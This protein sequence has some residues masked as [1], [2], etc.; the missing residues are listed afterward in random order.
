MFGLLA[1]SLLCL[2]PGIASSFPDDAPKIE[3]ALYYE[4]LCPDCQL[5]IRQQLYPTYLKVSDIINL[6][7]VPYG[8]AEER[9]IGDKWVFQCQHGPKECEGNLIETCAI[10]LLKDISASLPFVYCFEKNIEGSEE[11]TTVAQ[12]C[13]KSL[14]IDYDSIE[15]CVSGPLGNEL[16][17]KM[18]AMTDALEP[19]HQYVPWVTVNGKH[20]EK[21][22]NMAQRNLLK[23]VC[24]YY[25]GPK[26]KDCEKQEFGRCYKKVFPLIELKKALRVAAPVSELH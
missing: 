3:L 10:S 16:E 18:A 12:S 2:M 13:A 9:K 15:A 4:S 17:H 26:P 25:T 7:L 19:Q 6:T 11:P 8:N 23:L 14:K 5:F 1:W 22:Q 21:I 24:E 20:T